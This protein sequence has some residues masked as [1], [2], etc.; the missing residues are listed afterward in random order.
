[1]FRPEAALHFLATPTQETNELRITNAPCA[2]KQTE[3][4]P[5]HAMKMY[6]DPHIPDLSFFRLSSIQFNQHSN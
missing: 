2:Q 3:A 1:L 6:T 4:M 5:K